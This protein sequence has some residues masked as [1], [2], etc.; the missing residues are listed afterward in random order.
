MNVTQTDLLCSRGLAFLMTYFE[1]VI[2]DCLVDLWELS[3][4]LHTT[5][6]FLDQRHDQCARV[7]GFIIIRVLQSNVVLRIRPVQV[8]ESDHIYQLNSLIHHKCACCMNQQFV[9]KKK[10]LMYVVIC[11]P[12]VCCFQ[13]YI[14][15]FQLFN[16]VNDMQQLE[17]VF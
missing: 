3:G 1:Y 11:K 14:V 8:Y 4:F 10:T 12:T 13:W 17:I 7:N 2:A 15:V 9:A 6:V 5:F 16:Y